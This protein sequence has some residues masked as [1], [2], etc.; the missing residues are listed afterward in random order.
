MAD[1]QG[2]LQRWQG[3]KQ[4]AINGEMTLDKDTGEAL[5][6]ECETLLDNLRRRRCEAE[7]WASC[8][9]MAGCRPHRTSRA[10]SRHWRRWTPQT[11]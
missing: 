1:E 8:P 7:R 6:G 2:Q 10:N 9:G 3:L 5:A 11:G 4:Q